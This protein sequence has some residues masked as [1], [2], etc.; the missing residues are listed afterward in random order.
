[1]DKPEYII[2]DV[3]EVFDLEADSYRWIEVESVRLV[4]DVQVL[5]AE[6]REF[7]ACMVNE[8][9]LAMPHI[10]PKTF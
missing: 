3:V 4:H 6:G 10:Q 1:M 5:K 9:S 7:C 8:A 2:G